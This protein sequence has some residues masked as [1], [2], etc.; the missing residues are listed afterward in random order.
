MTRLFSPSHLLLA[1]CLSTAFIALSHPHGQHLLRTLLFEAP[2][3]DPLD[4]F[5]SDIG[6]P[7]SPLMFELHQVPKRRFADSAVSLN[8]QPYAAQLKAAGFEHDENL[9]H[10]AREIA[11]FYRAH[12]RLAP[13]GLLNFIVES[14]GGAFWGVRQ[15]VV[16]T[17]GRH[18]EVIDNVIDQAPADENNWMIGLGES[19]VDGAVPIRIIVALTARRTVSLEPISRERSSGNPIAISGR[20]HPSFTNVAALAMGPDGQVVALPVD[21]KNQRFSSVF[22]P[23]SGR[24]VVELIATGPVGP[25]P[26]TQLTFYV[27]EKI[28]TT[29]ESQWPPHEQSIDDLAEYMFGLINHARARHGLKPFERSRKLDLIAERHSLNMKEEVFVGHISKRSGTTANR[30]DHHGV[31]RS[32]HGENVA[33]NSSVTDAHRGLMESLGHRRNL[34]SPRFTKVG[35]S[36]EPSSLGWYVTQV[37]TEDLSEHSARSPSGLEVRVGGQSASKRSRYGALAY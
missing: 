2:Q 12:R 20:V 31:L 37:F 32:S 22:T 33:L 17:T 3:S 1:A 9:S 16:A 36:V 4:A 13:S 14:S 11:E 30:L 27:D 5:V 21:S 35:L 28:S 10:A 15:T 34:L 19:T 6:E 26:L 29:Y 24:W 7:G 18:D 8:D 23:S 25:V